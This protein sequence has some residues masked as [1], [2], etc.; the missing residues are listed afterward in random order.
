MVTNCSGLCSSNENTVNS[1]RSLTLAGLMVTALSAASI[2]FQSAPSLGIFKH[3]LYVQDFPAAAVFGVIL[4]TAA[5]LPGSWG[6]GVVPW[7]AR[8]PYPVA[9]LVWAILSVLTITVYQSHPLSMDE[10]A[11]WFQAKVF[12]EGKLA[13]NF[14]V[15]LVDWLIPKNFQNQFLIVNH[16]TGAVVSAYWPGFSLILAP[17]MALGIPWACNPLLVALSLLMLWK[18]AAELIPDEAG[19]GWVVLLALASPAFT[20]NGITFY[21]MPAHLLLNL[22]FSWL[23]LKPSSSRLFIAGLI[24]ALALTLHNPYPHV[25]F[26]IPWIGWLV[27]RTQLGW[28]SLPWLV[29]GYLVLLVPLGVG[30]SFFLQHL[31]STGVSM[32]ATNL[33]PPSSWEQFQSTILSFLRHFR[34]PDINIVEARMDGLIKLWLWST[35]LLLLLAWPR[36]DC[37]TNPRLLVFWISALITFFGYFLIP[38]DQGHG[39]GY[40]YFH[41]AFGALPLL[42]A[43]TLVQLRDT[44][45]NQIPGF[46]ARLSIFSLIICTSVRLW[47]IGQFIDSQL[48]QTPPI[49]NNET[50]VIFYTGGGY[51]LWDLVQNDPWLRN[52]VVRLDGRNGD[53]DAVMH[54]YFP[55]PY[56]I[57]SNRFGRSYCQSAR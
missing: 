6:N 41:S 27:L 3:L 5:L 18:L 26:A 50:C 16:T 30:W 1:I 38:Y 56:Q 49:Q 29:S 46:I 9:I 10:Y 36:R 39:W 13:G 19:R 32:Q 8:N 4:I 2:Y 25:L 48:A 20:L 17:F 44:R 43:S 53:N 35:P 23:V 33:A 28:L 57:R 34:L 7:L 12:A 15:G 14:P 21:S 52:S 40:R 24:G 47:Q 11:V 45:T 54:Q 31:V 55:G 51:Y 37:K 42:A 22:V